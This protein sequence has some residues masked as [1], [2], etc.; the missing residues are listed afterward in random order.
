MA[1]ANS[2]LANDTSITLDWA[3]VSGA[4]LYELEVATE[5]D[6]SGT[7]LVN[8]ATLVAS[9]KTFTDG[10]TND[11]KR[12]WRW[13]YS[14]DAGATWSAWSE[15]GSY[16]LNTSASGDVTLA[17]GKWAMFDPDAV[18]DIYTFA[19]FPVYAVAPMQ[20]PRIRERNRAGD[21]LSEFITIKDKISLGIDESHYIQHPQMREFRRFYSEHKTFFLAAYNNNTVDDVPN[22]WKVQ[23][24]SDPELS[25]MAGR[26]DLFTG[27][28]VFEEV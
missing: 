2:V 14:T 18:S 1:A 24:E 23:F 17:T 5:P 20:I 19:L 22:V 9:T 3:D 4:N 21:L 13:R 10:G 25:M 27:S 16:W 6:F 12:W 26:E 7:L 11:K 15:V 28:L 8:D